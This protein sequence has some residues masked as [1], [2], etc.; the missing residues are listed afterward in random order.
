MT[1]GTPPPIIDSARV[2]EFA[3]VPDHIAF[4]GNIHLNV[5]GEWLGRVA[6]LA[7]CR[8]YCNPND[9]L[10]LFCDEEW[11]SR[12]CIPFGSIEEA[13]LKAERGYTGIS[14]EWCET[15]YDDAVIADFLRDEYEVDPTTEWWL[16][17]CSFCQAE[18]EGKAITKGWATICVQCVNKF[19]A[20]M[21]EKEA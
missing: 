20:A 19:Y 5:G 14:A 1:F 11:N 8:N 9:I 10:L 6:N 21:H 7:V 16:F 2:L 13:K 17:R 15:P 12:G 18:V 3:N 4:T